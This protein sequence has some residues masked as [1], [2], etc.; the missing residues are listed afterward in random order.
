MFDNLKLY[1]PVKWERSIDWRLTQKRGERPEFYKKI[2][3]PY[4]LGLDYA[5][6]T[7]WVLQKIY[8]SHD[9][10]VS[11]LSDPKWFGNYVTVDW[12][13]YVTY[14]AHL[15]GV[16]VKSWQTVKVNQQIGTSWSTGNSSA[17]HLH[18]WLRSKNRWEWYQGRLDPTPYIFDWVHTTPPTPNI[19]KPDT[20]PINTSTIEDLKW[21]IDDKLFS[22]DM[23]NLTPERV[24]I[25]LW[26]VYNKLF[27]K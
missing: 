17:V 3:R 2:W 7:P 15:S 18:F 24:L 16:S 23:N 25:V 19:V 9:W 6:K 10:I 12:G 21:L 5:D 13:W 8:A 1:R 4:H 26:R 11:V 20:M 22:G 14:Y 27:T